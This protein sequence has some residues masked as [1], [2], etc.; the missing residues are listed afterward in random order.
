MGRSDETDRRAEKTV[1]LPSRLWG[2]VS[3][4]EAWGYRE[5]LYFLAWRDIK[6]RC[7]Q[8]ALGVLWALI[9]PFV[10]MVVFSV[11]FGC[12]AGISS[13]GSPYPVFVYAGLLP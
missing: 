13:D 7:K 6:V 4:R 5:L 1:I 8:A 3:L 11:I 12:L 10:K 9:Q 2:A